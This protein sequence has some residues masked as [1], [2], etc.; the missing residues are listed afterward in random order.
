MALQGRSLRRIKP[1]PGKVLC[2]WGDA[3]WGA[4]VRQGKY[5]DGRFADDLV[6]ACEALVRQWSPQ[7]AA[8]LG[9]LHPVAPS[10]ESRA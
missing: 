1:Q 5:R 7:P 8:G 9:D 2:V 4:L 6:T 3:G 10:S